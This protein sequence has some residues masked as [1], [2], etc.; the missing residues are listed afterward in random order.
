MVHVKQLSSIT[1]DMA[2][3]E[4]VDMAAM[5]KAGAIAFSEDGK[6]VMD[7]NL[8]KEAMKNAAN[9]GAL[10]MAHCEDKNLV[11]KGVLNEGGITKI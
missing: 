10:V 7:I 4:L 6:S 8:Y 1:K 2:G 5:K 3:N 9:L 11:G